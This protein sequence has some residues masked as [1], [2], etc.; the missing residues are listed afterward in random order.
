[1]DGDAEMDADEGKVGIRVAPPP[2]GA[3][4]WNLRSVRPPLNLQW[5]KRIKFLKGDMKELLRGELQRIA[6]S[7]A[8]TGV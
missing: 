1:M 4:E 3:V 2:E 7:A 5:H 6:A 8:T